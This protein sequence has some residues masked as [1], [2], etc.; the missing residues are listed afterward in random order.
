MIEG[1]TLALGFCVFVGVAL[2]AHGVTHTYSLINEGS[3]TSF[4]DVNA[5]GHYTAVII[6]LKDANTGRV[7]FPAFSLFVG[8][9]LNAEI[10]FP[11]LSRFRIAEYLRR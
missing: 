10:S 7:E 3:A 6:N 9:V 8:D 1:R 11:M 5:A 4:D 2:P